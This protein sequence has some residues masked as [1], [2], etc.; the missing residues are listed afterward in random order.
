VAEQVESVT[1]LG[2]LPPAACFFGVLEIT[3]R[4]ARA[5]VFTKDL[6]LALSRVAS[7]NLQTRAAVKAPR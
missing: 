5:G 1:F 3:P 6:W 4:D 7:V 2:F